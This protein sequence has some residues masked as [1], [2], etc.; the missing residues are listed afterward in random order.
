M[1]EY[2]TP[3]SL[4]DHIDNVRSALE[5][6]SADKSL[7]VNRN[8]NLLSYVIFTLKIKRLEE[9]TDALI[10]ELMEGTRVLERQVTE[11]LRALFTRYRAVL[12]LLENQLNDL[13]N[14]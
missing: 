1:I 11:E 10:G 12:S 5:S 4:G 13:E 6:I 8:A 7:L 2:P 14:K 9:A 3:R